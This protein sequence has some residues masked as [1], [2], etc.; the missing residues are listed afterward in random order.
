MEGQMNTE[1]FSEMLTKLL[2]E[3]MSEESKEEK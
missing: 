2:E 1:T 3:Q